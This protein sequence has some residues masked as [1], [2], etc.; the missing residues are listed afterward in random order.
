M[1]VY[2]EAQPKLMDR[3]VKHPLF[4][5]NVRRVRWW[6][7]SDSL[8][9]YGLLVTSWT[10]F[11]LLVVWASFAIWRY[12]VFVETYQG[13]LAPTP[14]SFNLPQ[15]WQINQD[16]ATMGLLMG[17]ASL[18]LSYLLDFVLM[19]LTVNSMSDERTSHRWDLIRLTPLS[20][21]SIIDAIYAAR[22]VR[23]WRV[24][25]IVV[26]SRL[27]VVL[28]FLVQLLA[29]LPAVDG[30]NLWQ[31]L[32]N[33]IQQGN[34]DYFMVSVVLILLALVIFVATMEP[35]WRMR[36]ITAL[37]IW[38]SSYVERY[39]VAIALAGLV[40]VGL[41]M[42]QVLIVGGYWWV[43]IQVMQDTRGEVEVALTLLFFAFI[44]WGI[45]Y[46]YFR[47]MRDRS[48][49]WALTRLGEID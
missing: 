18:G 48:H 47:F 14:F 10:V 13:N 45:I 29:I 40:L 30:E 19:A 25:M 4:G 43:L 8:M 12:W 46:G 28:V 26:A 20:L 44:A 24:T 7:S 42:S 6:Q 2:S 5:L 21:D 17:A 27:A 23:V 49:Y 36:G 22:Q 33:A 31:N 37:A 16:I 9:Q 1:I 3:A 39:V 15:P 34:V 35:I 41:W 38:I 11:S 32:L